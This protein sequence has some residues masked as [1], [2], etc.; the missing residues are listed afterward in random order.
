M[1]KRHMVLLAAVLVLAVVFF[2][3]SNPL[4][5]TKTFVSMYGGQIEKHIQAGDSVPEDL[6]CLD[7]NIWQGEHPMM[8]FMLSGWGIGSGTRYYGC[9]YSPDDVPLAFQNYGTALT[10]DGPESWTWTGEGDNHGATQR[11]QE[12]WFYF[13]AYF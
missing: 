2:Y 4:R 12:N 10:Q 6:G 3:S 5:H 1:K 7:V 13:E 8:E 11:I 9:Y